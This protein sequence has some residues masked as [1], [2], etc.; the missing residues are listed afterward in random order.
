MTTTKT[1]LTFEQQ[2][3][4]NE[5][6][7][8]FRANPSSAN[9]ERYNLF[10]YIDSLLDA[11]IVEARQTDEY[12]NPMIQLNMYE[13]KAVAE[14]LEKLVDYRERNLFDTGDWFLDVPR[15]V[16][17]WLKALSKRQQS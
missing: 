13:A 9:K 7:E 16:N 14:C 1:E 17:M 15:K 2:Q 5:Y 10:A 12:G 4:I 6:L 8:R 11:S 3:E